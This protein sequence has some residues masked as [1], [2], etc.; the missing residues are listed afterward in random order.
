MSA[1]DTLATDATNKLRTLMDTLENAA[2]ACGEWTPDDDT[3]YDTYSR[4][5][6]D[7]RLALAHAVATD[8]AKAALLDWMQ[9]NAA[10]SRAVMDMDPEA[11]VGHVVTTYNGEMGEGRTLHEAILNAYKMTQA[12]AQ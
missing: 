7:A 4:A 9:V 12:G 5:L 11:E 8:V 6:A 2:F 3:S 10:C 1:L